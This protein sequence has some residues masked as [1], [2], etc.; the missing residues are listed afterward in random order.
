MG[1]S[2]RHHL[3]SIDFFFFFFRK[4]ADLCRTQLSPLVQLSQSIRVFFLLFFV[5]R[6]GL[7]IRMQA[8]MKHFD[9]RGGAG[10]HFEIRCCS[11][12]EE[13]V[14]SLRVPNIRGGLAFL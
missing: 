5:C 11:W 12:Q 9:N 3:L 4:E 2:K 1:V 7:G 10:R 13:E 6:E 14:S 8:E